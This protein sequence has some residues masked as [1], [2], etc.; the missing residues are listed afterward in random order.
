MIKLF[1][2]QFIAIPVCLIALGG[3]SAKM[4]DPVLSGN[5]VVS[6][7]T[8]A[9]KI[10]GPTADK[11]Q[12]KYAVYGAQAFSRLQ[13][14]GAIATAKS[15]QALAILQGASSGDAPADAAAPTTGTTTTA[16]TTATSL[17]VGFPLDLLGHQYVF[18]AVVTGLSDKKNETLGRLKLTDLT[19]LHVTPRVFKTSATEYIF[20]LTGCVDKCEEGSEE[21]VLMT[22]PILG[23]DPK[24]EMVALDLSALGK[25]LNL[26]QMLDPTGE[27]TQ[28]ETKTAETVKAD[29]SLSTLVFDVAVTMTPKGDPTSANT[30]Q[31]T[32][33]WYLRLSSSFDPSFVARNATPGVGFFM[34]ERATASKIQRLKKPRALKGVGDVQSAHYYIKNVP[35]EYRPAFNKAFDGWNK[36]GQ[37]LFGKNILSYEHVEKTDPR[38]AEIVAGDA[39]FHVL[40]WD[41]DNLAPYGGLGPSLANQHTGEIF[42]A[43]VLV[44]GPKIV[45]LYT[46][47]FEA[48]KKAEALEE[49]GLLAEAAAVLLQAKREIDAKLAAPTATVELKLGNRLPFRTPAQDPTLEDPVMAKLEFEKVPKGYTY[50]QYMEGYFEELV[51]HELGHNLGLRH[52]FRGNLSATS[53]TDKG[54]VSSSIMEY[55]GRDFR[56]IS[57]I[58]KYDEMAMRYG[59]LGTAPTV[60]GGFCT[61]EDVPSDANPALSAECSRDDGTNDPFSFFL[62]RLERASVYLVAPGSADAPIWTAKDMDAALTTMLTNLGIYAKNSSTVAS[63]WTNFYGKPGRPRNATTV[64]SYVLRQVQNLICSDDLLAALNEKGSMS[65]KRQTLDNIQA[66]HAKTAA[67]MTKVGAFTAT[68]LECDN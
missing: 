21:N 31:F 68:E 3:C 32:T 29:F 13:N 33:R 35:A 22:I 46:A 63:K 1:G 39:R 4:A 64:K 43:N 52:N 56:H 7:D 20:A 65:A 16:T 57:A 53:L 2:S 27:Y 26:I 37:T 47:W 61:D 24:T 67:V 51:A 55:L 59:Y 12:E 18:G 54:K 10:I 62:D 9:H 41:L 28:L 14:L 25:S 23:V 5:R 60:L 8:D 15:A 11:T 44:Q 34:T 19:P 58:G 50:E 48:A 49:Q 40:E 45:E 36:L 6:S 17:T 42:S 30:T 38:Y 66:L